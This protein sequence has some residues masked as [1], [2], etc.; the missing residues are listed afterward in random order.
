M[1]RFSARHRVRKRAEFRSVQAAARKVVSA[2]FVFLMQ[3]APS[4][5][6]PRIGITA[7]RRVGNAVRRNRAKRLVRE[8]FRAC[9]DSWPRG[10]TTVVIV[11]RP[12]EDLRLSDVVAEWRAVHGKMRR[13]WQKMGLGSEP[14]PG[15]E[16]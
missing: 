4:E 5:Q 1:G 11:R 3:G 13:A 9:R 10:L 16:G 6:S 8:A 7:S 15:P 2:S 14:E 12:I